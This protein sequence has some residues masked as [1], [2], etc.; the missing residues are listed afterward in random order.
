MGRLSIKESRERTHEI[1]CSCSLY[2]PVFF[3]YGN[4]QFHFSLSAHTPGPQKTV[5]LSGPCRGDVVEGG[6]DCY[7]G[8]GGMGRAAQGLKTGERREG[9]VGQRRR[10]RLEGE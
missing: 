10:G 4:S 7:G 5:T 8:R 2:C 6:G 9:R 3:H 1:V